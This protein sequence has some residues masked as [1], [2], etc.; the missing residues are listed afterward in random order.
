MAI[1]AAMTMAIKPNSSVT[2]M[3]PL[4]SSA[5]G[6][7]LLNERQFAEQLGSRRLGPDALALSSDELRGRLARS[8]RAIKVALLD[9]NQTAPGEEVRELRIN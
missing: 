3:R 2:G 7:R 9:P 1:A 6:L 5:T 8:R 4:S